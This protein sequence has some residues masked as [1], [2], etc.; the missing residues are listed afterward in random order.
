MLI[1]ESAKFKSRSTRSVVLLDS[2]GHKMITQLEAELEK[3]EV[4]YIQEERKLNQLNEKYS[5]LK[6]TDKTVNVLQKNQRY[7][8]R[9]N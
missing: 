5:V 8:D 7:D 4:E 1:Q 9:Q 6:N 2:V 3:K